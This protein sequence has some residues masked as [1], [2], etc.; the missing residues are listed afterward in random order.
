MNRIEILKKITF[1]FRSLFGSGVGNIKLIR[2]F[3]ERIISLTLPRQ[4]VVVQIG[5]CKLGMTI[6]GEKGI[7]TLG[8]SLLFGNGYEVQT[9]RLFKSLLTEDANVVDV[10][11]HIGYYTII[12][13]NKSKSGKVWAF[14]PEP[15]NYE[16]LVE[17]IKLNKAVN[18]KTF[19]KAVG[20]ENG[21][22]PLFVPGT[23]SGECSLVH[24]SNRPNKVVD[25]EV[26]ALD[27]IL[28]GE[29]ID[30]IKIDVEGGE[31]G[32]LLGAKELIRSNPAIKIFAELSQSWL[33]SA[34]YSCADYWDVLAECGLHYIYLINDKQSLLYRVELADIMDYLETSEGTN[35]LCSKTE[36]DIPFKAR[37]PYYTIKNLH[38]RARKR[39]DVLCGLIQRGHRILDVGCGTGMNTINPLKYLPIQ[40]VAID[41]DKRSLEYAIESHKEVNVQFV[42]GN[43]EDYQ[44]EQ[45]FDLI[46]C[47]HILEHLEHPS[48]MLR[49]LKLLL[50]DDGKLFVALPNGYGC[51]EFENFV[52][53]MIYRTRWCR[54]LIDRMRV[55]DGKDSLNTESQHIQFFTINAIEK[56]LET[57]GWEVERRIN[58]EF[59]GGVIT[60]RTILRPRIISEWNMKVA[61]KLPSCLSNAWILICRKK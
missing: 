52:P 44:C 35:L 54:K 61:S 5:D 60:D 22:S 14:E 57:C 34:G 6:G 30:I 2:W 59:I 1:P 48:R 43:G 39:L 27:S 42:L 40:I 38:R 51:F 33:K 36:V 11:A 50:K 19:Q 45:K 9:T 12:A 49:N 21:R 25:V 47:S 29:K 17:N 37:I 10:G 7:D 16:A 56:L 23:F 18:V 13:A 26:V 32:V 15:N 3:F 55:K 46:V 53:R 24:K 41:C 4:Y 28:A 31:I 8:G 20:K 58:E